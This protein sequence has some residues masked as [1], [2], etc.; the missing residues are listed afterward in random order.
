MSKARLFNEL[1]NYKYI[2]MA[3]KRKK[4]MSIVRYILGTARKLTSFL[5]S[6]G[7]CVRRK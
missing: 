6:Q 5:K 4:D 1:P 2:E 3:K 7:E